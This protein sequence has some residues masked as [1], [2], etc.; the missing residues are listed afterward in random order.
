MNG[1]PRKYAKMGFSRGWK[2]YKASTRSRSAYRAPKVTYM[3]KRRKSRRSRL[4]SFARKASKR[5]GVGN[6]AAIFQ[7]DAM[8]YGAARQFVS[9]KL[10]PIS[11][12][13]PLGSLGDEIVMGTL[14]Y[15]VAKKAGSGM[16]G[17]VA[18]KGL[19]IENARVGE[20]I[21]QGGL[22]LLGQGTS[23]S[24]VYL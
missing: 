18:R 14:C 1:L 13:I 24:G 17:N 19:V 10:A 23:P 12:K 20:A 7:A 9:D 22:P 3:A 8:I 15:F 4:V 6:S 5:G 16:L 2:A 21:V 11:S